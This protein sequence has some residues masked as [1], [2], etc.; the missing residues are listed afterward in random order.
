MRE[1]VILNKKE[2]KRLILLNEVEA[3]RIRLPV[4]AELLGL[5]ARQVRRIRSGYRLEGAAA[6]AHGN[7]GRKPHNSL[8][9]EMK[10][11]VL[12]LAKAAYAG[13]NTQHFT[14]LLAE[15][16]N[17]VMSRSTVRRI[18]LQSGI[19]SP[20]KRRAPRHRSRRER[21]PQEGMLLQID[22]SRHYWL[23]G[24]G[25]F[26][27]LIGAIDDATGKVLGAV[28]REQEDAQGYFLL[29]RGIVKRYGIPVALYH[30]RHGIFE[31]SKRET[32][33]IE[34]QLAGKR[35]PTQFGRLLEEL[36]ITSIA[37]GSPQAK[38]RV[39]RLWGTFQDRLVSELRLAK[40]ASIPDANRALQDYLQRHNSRFAVTA[41]KEGQAYRQPAAG[42]S[43]DQVFCFKY[44]RTVGLDNVIRF[45]EHR[46]Q[47]ALDNH[48][49]SY[50]RAKV[51]VHERMD[52]SMAVQYRDH[53]LTFKP[54][55]SEAPVLRT[56]KMP[57][58]A[59]ILT[60]PLMATATAQS[61][62]KKHKPG[63]NH[64][65]RHLPILHLDRA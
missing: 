31:R 17:I 8:A 57:R 28:F 62:N 65:W 16:E 48:R 64:P 14:E 12:S 51:E 30:D 52:G 33:S 11:R 43:F 19:S 23:E 26:L 20:R 4:A 42:F 3:R 40:V 56:R 60:G 29:I 25:P 35:T 44:E 15:R 54:A 46:L 9:D 7:R 37:T 5:S 27:S 59:I 45:G 24:R 10:G 36:G 63:I 2:Q 50:A 55:P 61:L 21:Y 47:I 34:E 39:E 32:E 41:A 38:G 18:L 22:G 1:E 49:M 13:C 53:Y 6:L 58:P